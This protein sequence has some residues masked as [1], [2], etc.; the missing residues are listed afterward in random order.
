MDNSVTRI[1]DLPVE[2]GLISQSTSIQQAPKIPTNANTNY[3]ALNPHPNPYGH[4]PPSIPNNIPQPEFS[5]NAGGGG[6]TYPPQV[7]YS[8]QIPPQIPPQ[9]QLPL[10]PRD[11]PKNQDF[12]NLDEQVQP[13]YI[14]P[15]PK[16]QSSQIEEFMK[17]YELEKE[18]ELKT[19][20]QKKNKSA[21]ME[22][23]VE[24]AQ[25]PIFVAILFFLFNMPFINQLFFRKLSFLQIYDSDGNF[26]TYGLLLKST[27]FGLVYAFFS[28]IIHWLG[29]I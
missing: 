5:Q 16:V 7:Q 8:P 22:E 26:N 14:P 1:L 4:P 9:Q 13:N 23:I 20:Q 28:G 19:N 21:R 18:K 2:N 3:T 11:I 15:I 10:P 29:D 6:Y 25:I 17:T 27:F 24:T 12:Y